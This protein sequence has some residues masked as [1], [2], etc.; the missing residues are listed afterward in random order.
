MF[1]VNTLCNKSQCVTA[2]QVFVEAKINQHF[3]RGFVHY[4]IIVKNANKIYQRKQ[5]SR[6]M[7]TMR[8]IFSNLAKCE[9]MLRVLFV[10]VVS[11]GIPP[12]CKLMNHICETRSFLIDTAY[13]AKYG[14]A[15]FSTV[16]MT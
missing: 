14:S 5:D 9:G 15:S 2:N 4:V 7:I 10:C 16:L 11:G 8:D 12:H 3:V 13:T 6:H 1:R